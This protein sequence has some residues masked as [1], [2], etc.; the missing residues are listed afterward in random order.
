[1]KFVSVRDFRSKSGKV[2][3]DLAD[4]KDI[5]LTSN[6]KPIALVSSVSEDTMDDSLAALRQARA[7]MAVE[8]MQSRSV[9][10]GTSTMSLK[11][12]NAEIAAVRKGR[13]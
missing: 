1:M 10:K 9:S 7:M 13:R 2:W 4:E 3:K 12:I 11:E 8:R 5:L 6:G